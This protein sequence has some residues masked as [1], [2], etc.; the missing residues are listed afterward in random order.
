MQRPDW[1]ARIAQNEDM[2]PMLFPCSRH[3]P[4]P[5]CMQ[6]TGSGAC[7]L[8]FPCHRG[9]QRRKTI[10]TQQ[11]ATGCEEGEEENENDKEE[12]VKLHA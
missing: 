11:E 8:E 2:L 3:A 7:E 5:I 4:L 1:L 10:K 9:T 12:N 6:H